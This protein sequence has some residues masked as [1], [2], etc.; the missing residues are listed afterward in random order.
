MTVATDLSS[1]P[2]SKQLKVRTETVHEALDQRI[3]AARP[4]ADRVRYG[5]FLVVQFLFHRDIDALYDHPALAVLLPD[6]A[7]RRRLPLIA[8]DLSDLGLDS[9]AADSAPHFA[10]A[11]IDRSEALGWLYVAEG[12]NLGAAFLLKAASA[13]GLGETL[14]A[15]HL[16]GHPDGR[17]QHW[18]SFTAALDGLTLTPEGQDGAFAGANAAFMRVRSLVETHLNRD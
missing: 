11:S 8:Q 7:E 1:A 16:G 13:L 18:R 10:A 6:L 3:M 15:R 14:G 5:N 2:F 12:S 9:P 4:F 17:G